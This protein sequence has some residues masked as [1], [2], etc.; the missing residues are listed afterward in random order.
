MS[1]V[2]STE[3]LTKI[4]PAKVAVNNV[5]IHVERGD[6]YGLIGKN[7]A[8][9]TTL[10][11]I[12]LGLTFSNGGSVSLFGSSENLNTSRK[13]IGSLIEDPGLYK[14][15]TATENLTRFSILYGA[16]RS[17]IPAILKL[18][19]LSDAGNKKVS[20]FSLGMKQ[21]LGLA[22]ALLNDPEILVLDEPM[23]GLDPAGIKDMRDLFKKLNEERGV[24]IIISS[25][26]LEELAKIVNVYGII[27]NG[28][29]IEE[30]S[31]KELEEKCVSHIKIVCNDYD[32]AKKIL[33]E[34]F[35]DV[36]A[37]IRSDG[38]YLMTASI[39]PA[40]I[41]TLLVK[42]DVEVSAVT[43][44]VDDFENFFIERLG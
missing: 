2:V 14:N 40:K 3:N 6:I 30:I 35:P 19:G 36:S 1:Y 12:L 15:C 9:K 29:L 11:K 7:G 31:S 34:S 21:R 28:K 17:K 42:G 5:S 13:K 24:T 23:N 39:D 32:A 25:H 43:P 18:V 38:L 4:Y 33:A 20:A 27:N 26:I 8:G 16:D 22:I 10:M 41:N 44:S 37:E